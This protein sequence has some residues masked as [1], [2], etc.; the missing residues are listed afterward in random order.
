[1]FSSIKKYLEQISNELELNLKIAYK[2]NMN[3]NE[4]EQRFF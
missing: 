2:L 3:A 4:D 1:M